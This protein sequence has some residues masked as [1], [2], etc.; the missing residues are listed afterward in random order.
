MIGGTLHLFPD[1]FRVAG[2]EFFFSIKYMLINHL[3]HV[4]LYTQYLLETGRAGKPLQKP[5]DSSTSENAFTSDP[6]F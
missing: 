6:L 4:S 2:E 3:L 1:T 5:P